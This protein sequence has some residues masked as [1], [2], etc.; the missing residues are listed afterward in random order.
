LFEEKLNVGQ[1]AIAWEA[2]GKL[3]VEDVEVAP[4]RAHE[5]RIKILWTGVRLMAIVDNAV[6]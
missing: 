3:S 5:V 4:P 1:A 2:G 6:S